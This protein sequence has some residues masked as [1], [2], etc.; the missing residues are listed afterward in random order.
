M[1]TKENAFSSISLSQFVICYLQMPVRIFVKMAK[2]MSGGNKTARI[3]RRFVDIDEFWPPCA[4]PLSKKPAVFYRL[5]VQYFWTRIRIFIEELWKFARRVPA[6]A[7][8][9]F[10]T[11][12]FGTLRRFWRSYFLRRTELR[13]TAYKSGGKTA[14]LRVHFRCFVKSPCCCGEKRF[15]SL[16][17]SFLFCGAR[18]W[19]PKKRQKWQTKKKLWFS[20]FFV[21]VLSVKNHN[22]KLQL[23]FWVLVQIFRSK[24]HLHFAILGLNFKIAAFL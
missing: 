1:L 15:F 16:Q 24:F 17:L 10:G 22:L 20:S 12:F 18:F 19:G 8:M 11:E 13:S 9:S 5:F 23:H 2:M 6:A 14:I 3:L 7:K 21:G 4:N